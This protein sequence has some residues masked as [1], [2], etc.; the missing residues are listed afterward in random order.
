LT[1]KE[2]DVSDKLTHP[3][4]LPFDVNHCAACAMSE[5]SVEREIFSTFCEKMNMLM[6][7]SIPK[8]ND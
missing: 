1:S 3:D 8:S 5:I 7:T 4:Q 2:V 6:P